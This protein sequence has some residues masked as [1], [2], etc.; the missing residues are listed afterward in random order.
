MAWTK[1]FSMHSVEWFQGAG[2]ATGQPVEF[3]RPGDRYIN[4]MDGMVWVKH[5]VGPDGT[6][7]M[8]QLSL[9]GS[10]WWVQAGPPSPTVGVARD[11]SLDS[12]TGQ[13]YQHSMMFASP[14]EWTLMPGVILKGPAGPRGPAGTL[15]NPVPGRI[16][17]HGGVYVRGGL[18]LSTTGLPIVPKDQ[19]YFLQ[20]DPGANGGAVVRRSTSRH[21][22]DR[23]KAI[24]A[25]TTSVA[26]N[27][28]IGSTGYLARHS[29]SGVHKTD[30]APLQKPLDAVLALG[31]GSYRS[32]LPADQDRTP[33][34]AG[35]ATEEVVQHIPE[36]WSGADENGVLEAYD[37]NAV[38]AYLVGAF[39][40]LVQDHR[41]EVDQ[42]KARITA[43]EAT[44]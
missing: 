3:G 11:M 26:V 44:A 13:V 41:T 18:L 17:A 2:P 31:V 22:A 38:V 20:F 39:H 16:N 23:G 14:K 24:Y 29:S 28:V 43:L 25:R 10:R 36:A 34:F 1:K 27:V 32:T 6:W 21:W 42:L 30:W 8:K 9:H 5:D 33:K 19:P 12:V 15:P 37:L 40:Q 7:S 35:M 4:T